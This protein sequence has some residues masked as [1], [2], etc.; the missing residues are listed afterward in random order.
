MEIIVGSLDVREEVGG[1]QR[2]TTFSGPGRHPGRA[3]TWR[4]GTV[5]EDE[6]R[7]SE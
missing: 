4:V 6:L 2:P 3:S 7:R 5:G 1:E